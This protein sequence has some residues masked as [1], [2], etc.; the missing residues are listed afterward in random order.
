[1]KPSDDCLDSAAVQALNSLLARHYTV[2]ITPAHGLNGVAVAVF[3]HLPP[4][5]LV[6]EGRSHDLSRAMHRAVLSMGVL[7]QAPQK[8][9]KG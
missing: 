2:R 1:M 6:G 4:H 7:E 9:Q 3:D 5:V 8:A